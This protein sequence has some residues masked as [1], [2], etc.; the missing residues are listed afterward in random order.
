MSRNGIYPTHDW[1]G[2][3]RH[4]QTVFLYMGNFGHTKFCWERRYVGWI[5]WGQNVTRNETNWYTIL[6]IGWG[7]GRRVGCFAN[8]LLHRDVDLMKVSF[9]LSF[10]ILSLVFLFLSSVFLFLSWIFLFLSSVFLFLSSVFLF[11][12]SVVLFPDHL[13]SLS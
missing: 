7:V 9:S 3:S 13:L 5:F 6:G 1:S 4:I 10:L 2:L 12:S 8:K 11:L